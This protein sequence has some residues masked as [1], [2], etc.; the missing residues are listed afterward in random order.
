MGR[1]L[2][3]TSGSVTPI[4]RRTESGAL[5]LFEPE[6]N[7][8]I[9]PIKGTRGRF[10]L[11]GI[12]EE[13]ELESTYGPSTCVRI[14]FRV[15][16]ASGNAGALYNGKRFTVLYTWKISA[17]SA[18]GKLIGALRGRPV[19]EGEEINPDDYI[20]TVFT[21]TTGVS[22]NG[23]NTKFNPDTIEAG[24]VKLSPFVVKGSPAAANG[25]SDDLA[26]DLSDD[27]PYDELPQ[28]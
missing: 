1:I 7:E 2:T 9:R 3:A 15:L 22:E 6:M 23:E 26:D 13:F 27:D 10:E 11:T 25:A 5:E 14:E 18:L 8:Y 4:Y 12:S 16:K 17:K 20:G 24:S 28:G 19:D 21:G